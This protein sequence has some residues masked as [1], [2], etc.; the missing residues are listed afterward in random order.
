MP[1]PEPSP[2]VNF[3][4]AFLWLAQSLSNSLEQRYPDNG[5][6]VEFFDV[7]NVRLFK[8]KDL[9]KGFLFDIFKPI[10]GIIEGL[11]Q[12]GTGFF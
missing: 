2:S 7:F 6:R 1:W 4:R 8:C 11:G 3:P 10:L 12:G 9:N 5:R